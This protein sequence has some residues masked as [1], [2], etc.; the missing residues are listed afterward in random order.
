MPGSVDLG[1][2]FASHK[3]CPSWALGSDL[4]WD[5]VSGGK[6]FGGVDPTCTRSGTEYAPTAA[7][8]YLPFAS[9]VLARTDLGLQNVPTRTNVLPNNS[10][11]G[12]TLGT[13]GTSPNAGAWSGSVLGLT[14]E[15][16]SLGTK[17]G[18]PVIGI[19]FTGLCNSSSTIS[20]EC[21]ATTGG[22]AASV[23][24]IWTV[25]SLL[26]VV[27]NSGSTPT[28]VFGVVERNSS[29][30]SLGTQ[31]STTPPTSTLA[32]M[33]QTYTLAQATVAKITPLVRVN[34]VSGQTYD[35]TVEV[36]GQQ[37]ELGAFA[38][39]PILTTSAAVTLNG[40]QNVIDLTGRLSQG[41]AGIIQFT[42][43]QPPTS[44]LYSRLLEI[45]SNGSTASVDGLFIFRSQTA[46]FSMEA[47]ESSSIYGNTSIP[48]NPFVV[49]TLY[50]LV[51]SYGP[52]YLRAQ[53][54][55]QVASTEDTSVTYPSN[56]NKLII[57]AASGS[58]HAYQLT[59]KLALKFG[60][61]D[62]TTFA[63][64]YA[65]AVLAAT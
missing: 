54:V 6:Y 24:Q 8:L 57:G 38:S 20:F 64:M 62:A 36:A 51:F 25:S 41:V 65:K 3:R 46:G 21:M 30:G 29:D 22:V 48:P 5:F 39:A 17:N 49:D 58:N 55:G 56:L 52:N 19:R 15:I 28:W 63:A 35:F 27:V 37:L 53:I 34:V 31:F 47:R 50:T 26:S 2:S 32:H 16:V 9:N 18:L 59:K 10:N 60:P 13:P 7:G 12:A 40:D 33:A 1:F 23:G 61:Q 44:G 4:A 14:R 11:T 45:Y 42:S 43:K